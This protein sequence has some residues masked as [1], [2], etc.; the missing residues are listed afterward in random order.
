MHLRH[1]PAANAKER[2][3]SF[4][5][6]AAYVIASSERRAASTQRPKQEQ[7]QR[8]AR[9]SVCP[10][11][12][13]DGA[14]GFAVVD[15]VPLEGWDMLGQ[16]QRTVCKDARGAFSGYSFRVVRCLRLLEGMATSICTPESFQAA[17]EIQKLIPFQ[18]VTNM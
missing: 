3:V 14:K 15:N 8:A 11:A 7:L 18:N 4:S 9:K 16:L 5:N 2:L 6:P 17:K 1:V 12:Q 13:P 10:V